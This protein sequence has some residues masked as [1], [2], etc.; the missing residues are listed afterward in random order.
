MGNQV[1]IKQKF[2][3]LLQASEESETIDLLKEILLTDLNS[4]SYSKA[5]YPSDIRTILERNPSKIEWII[6][7]INQFL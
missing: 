4:D 3:N 5:I 1:G 7:Y 6:T 2:V